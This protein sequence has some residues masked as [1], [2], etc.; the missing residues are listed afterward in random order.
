MSVQLPSTQ[1]WALRCADD[2]EFMLAA[3]YWN[4]GLTLVVGDEEHTLPVSAGRPDANASHSDG[5]IKLQ[6]DAAVWE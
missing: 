5:I 2:G 3:R 1:Q 4:G 6:A